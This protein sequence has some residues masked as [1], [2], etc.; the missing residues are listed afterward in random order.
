MYGTLLKAPLINHPLHTGHAPAYLVR[1]MIKLSSLIVMATSA[2]RIVAK[3]DN[4]GYVVNYYAP[5]DQWAKY[6]PIY[7]RRWCKAWR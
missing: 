4:K 5:S 1:K 3:Q 2:P 6:S 7:T